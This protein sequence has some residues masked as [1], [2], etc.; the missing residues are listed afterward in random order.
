MVRHNSD[1]LFHLQAAGHFSLQKHCRFQ[2]IS[3]AS[4]PL[5]VVSSFESQIQVINHFSVYLIRIPSLHY[6]AKIGL[7]V[8][9]SLKEQFWTLSGSLNPIQA[10]LFLPFKGPRGVF[11]DP[12][13]ISGTITA[14]PMKLCTVI[15]PLKTYQNTKRNFQN[16]IYDITMTSLLKTMAKFGLPWNKE[17]YTSFERQWWELSENVIFIEIEWLD[18]TLWPFK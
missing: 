9:G 3:S 4:D 13:M 2:L 1:D 7:H 18:Q 12:L 6:S 10:R 11:R 8:P 16:M 14:S 17:N 5:E 15:A